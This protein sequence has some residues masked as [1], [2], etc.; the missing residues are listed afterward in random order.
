MP[1]PATSNSQPSHPS[2]PNP[3]SQPPTSTAT[4][5][6]PERIINYIVELHLAAARVTSA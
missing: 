5:H 1:S 6:A 2:A 3:N 4:S